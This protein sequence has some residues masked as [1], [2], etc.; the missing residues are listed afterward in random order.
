M[1]TP[2]DKYL[3]RPLW[4][5]LL[6]QGIS[7]LAELLSVLELEQKDLPVAAT[8]EQF[9]L[10]VPRGFVARMKKG[11]CFDPLL[12][13]VLPQH[14]ELINDAGFSSDPLAELNKNPIPGL[15]HK[16]HGRVLLTL[17]G[18]CA[19]HCR[20]CFRQHFPY[21]ENNPGRVGWQKAIEYIATQSEI[22]E[23]I[24]SGGDPLIATDE[25]LSELINKISQVPH[26]S[27]LR[28]HTRLP[29]VLPERITKSLLDCLTG[30]R[31]KVVLVVHC[32]HPNEID[33][34]VGDAMRLIKQAG[35][36][37]LNQSVLLRGINDDEKILFNLCQRLFA[38]DVL[39]Y[40]LHVLDKV[41][42]TQHFDVPEEK[43]IALITYLRDHLPGYL[44]PKLVREVPYANS[45]IPVG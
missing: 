27:I 16:Y 19:I 44:V 28:I 23:V 21:Q 29:I 26:V 5:N 2:S 18:S 40:Y 20:Y 42:G 31:L 1:I 10:R 13:Q 24:F 34:A 25:Y 11:D 4:Q 39:P 9:P 3:Q 15:L 32:N 41:R 36:L 14:Q 37:L 22:T 45:K 6:N 17:T 38:A 35:I 7:T 12:L 43:A 33:D 8:T 30:T